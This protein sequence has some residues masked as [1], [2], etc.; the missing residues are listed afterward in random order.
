M[1]VGKRRGKGKR[2]K[3]KSMRPR[4]SEHGEEEKGKGKDRTRTSREERKQEADE[5]I[6]TAEEK[7]KSWVGIH[8]KA[9]TQTIFSQVKPVKVSRVL[10]EAGWSFLLI[11]AAH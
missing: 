2:G 7:G 10:T 4:Q 8:A 6:N 1:E 9:H 3:G 11:A 5:G